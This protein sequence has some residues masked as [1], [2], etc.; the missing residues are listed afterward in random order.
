[1]PF[2]VLIGTKDTQGNSHFPQRRSNATSPTPDLVNLPTQ[3][4]FKP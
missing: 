4:D 3:I 1:V 2:P